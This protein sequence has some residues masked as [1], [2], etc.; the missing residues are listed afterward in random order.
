M[1]SQKK[2]EKI[3]VDSK[4][5]QLFM[6]ALSNTVDQIICEAMDDEF[7]YALIVYKDDMSSLSGSQ[8]IEPTISILTKIV[9]THL[10]RESIYSSG[11]E[12]GEQ[13]TPDTTH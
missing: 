12:S 5:F 4:E 3:A 7:N 10:S 13:S 8:D 2:T 6:R 1:E 11:D 9:L